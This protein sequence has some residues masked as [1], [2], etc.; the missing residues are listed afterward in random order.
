MLLFCDWFT[1][2]RP[3]GRH[4]ADSDPFPGTTALYDGF[5][6]EILPVAVLEC[7][8]ICFRRPGILAA[9]DELVH[10]HKEVL[11]TVRIALRMSA[12]IVRVPPCLLGKQRRIFDDH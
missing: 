5:D 1:T 2:H 4:S 11:R 8:K 6:D 10:V 3:P 9:A 7:R 12:R